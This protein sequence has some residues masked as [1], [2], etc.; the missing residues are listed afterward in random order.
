ME[1]PFHYLLLET[2]INNS[3][4]TFGENVSQLFDCVKI[5]Q[6]DISLENLYT[7]PN[8]LD[9]VIFDLWSKL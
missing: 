4:E 5:V 1:L 6:S 9:Y 3:C 7:E 8:H 2:F